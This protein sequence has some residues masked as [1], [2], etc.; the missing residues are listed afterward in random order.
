MTLNKSEKQFIG[1]WSGSS[2]RSWILRGRGIR[3]GTTRKHAAIIPR[4]VISSSQF[5]GEMTGNRCRTKLTF[6]E[7]SGVKRKVCQDKLNVLEAL[8]GK[9]RKKLSTVGTM[10]RKEPLGGFNNLRQDGFGVALFLV[11][12]RHSE[13]G[14]GK[15]GIQKFCKS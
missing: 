6:K 5:T 14:A 7:R 12:R 4:S 13:R 10:G 8:I 11:L 15:A 1:C 3:R 9:N 2:A